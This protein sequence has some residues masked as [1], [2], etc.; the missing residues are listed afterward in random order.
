MP[1]RLQTLAAQGFRCFNP[2]GIVIS[3]DELSC[4]IG[5]NGAGKTAALTALRRL[6]GVDA[7]ERRIRPDDFFLKDGKLLSD[8]SERSLRLEAT[9]VIVSKGGD[10]EDDLAGAAV[11][12]HMVVGEPGG[13]LYLRVELLATWHDDGTL[14]GDIEQQLH[15]ITTASDQMSEIEDSRRKMSGA[16]RALI[17]AVYVSATRDPAAEVRAIAGTGLGRLLRGAKW[18]DDL[19]NLLRD[20]TDDLEGQLGNESAL[21]AVRKAVEGRWPEL[22]RGDRHAKASLSPSG[23]E[24]QD[25]VSGLRPSFSGGVDGDQMGVD[26]LSD[27]FKSLFSL[28]FTTALMDVENAIRAGDVTGFDDNAVR[29]PILTLLLVEE[30]ENHVSPHHLG[31]V[32]QQLRAVS[33]S[34][35][36]QTILTSH[37]PSVVRRVEPTDIRYFR[38]GERAQGVQV[39]ALEL[40]AD[41]TEEGK[42][43]RE[44]VRAYPELYFSRLVILGEGASEETVISRLLRSDGHDL[45]VEQVSVVP[46]GGR[47]VNHFWRLLDQLGLEYVTLLDLDRCRTGGGWHRVK[48][49]IE[50]LLKCGVERSDVLTVEDDEGNESVM[51]DEE[52]AL[53]GSRD[54]ADADLDR[55]VDDL[56]RHDVYFSS[57]LDIDQLMLWAFPSEY[58]AASLSRPRVPKDPAKRAE[59]RKR[60]ALVVLGDQ[61]IPDYYSE[62]LKL[63]PWYRALFLH[64]S[65]PGAHLAA[66]STIDDATL[67][68]GCP[69]PLHA[70][71]EACRQ[72]LSAPA[73]PPTAD[74]EH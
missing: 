70:M 5:P 10:T 49:V 52:F 37:S 32:V 43:V 14:E 41:S 65:K 74:D 48:Y 23:A 13:P 71:I 40:P 53:L 18:S 31:R 42:F 7:S 44:A 25:L 47:H 30:P 22:Y 68:E 15:W 63:F 60:A 2:E 6:F 16:D 45:D 61:G 51:D 11:F 36:A 56:T 59:Y 1:L 58:K 57:P 33:E 34:E 28:A 66:L 8:I 17:R 46:L 73:T 3:L 64:G 26:A 20:Q 54:D 19:R 9:F 27:G 39:H 38:G 72:K 29:L 12:E 21:D 69:E 35:F 50:Q 4:F 24:L 67:L 62:S 55:W